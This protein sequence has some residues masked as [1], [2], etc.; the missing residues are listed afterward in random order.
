MLDA[1]AGV[2]ALLLSLFDGFFGGADPAA[3]LDEGL[4]LRILSAS[5]AEIG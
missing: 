4:Q 1:Q 3:F 5:F 2:D